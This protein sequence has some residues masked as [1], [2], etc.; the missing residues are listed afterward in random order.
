MVLLPAIGIPCSLIQCLPWFF[1]VCENLDIPKFTQKIS[2]TSREKRVKVQT[3]K[4]KL[5]QNNRL[6][7]VLADQ[8]AMELARAQISARDAGSNRSEKHVQF[9][10]ESESESS[11]GDSDEDPESDFDISSGNEEISGKGSVTGV[12]LKRLPIRKDRI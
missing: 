5:G 1:D 2:D 4:F 10:S 6:R 3:T 8:H 9:L 12:T 11:E 7:L